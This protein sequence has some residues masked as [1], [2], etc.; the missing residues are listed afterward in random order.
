MPV[1]VGP[2]GP[3]FV[4]VGLSVD[5]GLAV[6]VGLRVAVAVAVEEEW[7]LE[8]DGADIVEGISSSPSSARIPMFRVDPQ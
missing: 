3:G 6:D 8:I 1:C 7:E 4:E 2:G 5:V